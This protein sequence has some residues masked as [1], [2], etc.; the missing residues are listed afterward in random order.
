MPLKMIQ[1]E[2]LIELSILVWC[3]VLRWLSSMA[4]DALCVIV[5][6]QYVRSI[7]CIETHSI[8]DT[9]QWCIVQYSVYAFWLDVCPHIFWMTSINGMLNSFDWDGFYF[10]SLKMKRKIV[11]VESIFLLNEI[12]KHSNCQLVSSWMIQP[13]NSFKLYAFLWN[14][15]FVYWFHLWVKLQQSQLKELNQHFVFVFAFSFLLNLGGMQKDL[16][17]AQPTH[18]IYGI[19]EERNKF[20]HK[21]FICIDVYRW[22]N[23]Y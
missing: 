11:V 6:L 4:F 5:R 2:L 21:I 1:T 7:N 23:W 22:W 15:S 3:D 20:A 13:K 10:R 14:T 16:K 18:T 12:E 8:I 17:R 9:V 19:F